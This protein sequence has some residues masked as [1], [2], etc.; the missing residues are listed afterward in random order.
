MKIADKEHS[1]V[2]TIKHALEKAHKFQSRGLCR[3]SC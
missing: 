1:A 2:A 3:L